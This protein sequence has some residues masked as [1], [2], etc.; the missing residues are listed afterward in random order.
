M[1]SAAINHVAA[2]LNQFLRRAYNLSEDIVV[3]SNILAQDGSIAPHINN[4]IVVC[5]A[6]IEKDT[7]A[8]RAPKS[9]SG[10][11]RST[12]NSTPVFL[13]LYVLVAANFSGGNYSE[14]LKFIS[15]TISFFQRLPVFDHQVTPDLDQRIEKLILDIENLKTHE[16]SNLWT[17]LS[18][19]YLPS[20]LYKVRMIAFDADDI[21]RQVPSVGEPVTSVSR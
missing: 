10:P 9:A 4:K 12:V 13:N 5:L 19:R 1:I 8:H 20:V 14:A 18:G 21:V 6:N 17:V 16:L 7:V 15:S 3:V 2:H 11:A